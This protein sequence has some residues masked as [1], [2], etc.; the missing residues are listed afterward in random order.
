MIKSGALGFVDAI[1]EDELV[2]SA[3]LGLFEPKCVTGLNPLGLRAW[4]SE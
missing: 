4:D 2:R 1:D 3:G